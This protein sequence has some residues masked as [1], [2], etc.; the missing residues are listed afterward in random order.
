[1]YDLVLMQVCDAVEDREE[2]A[3]G[4]LKM[5]AVDQGRHFGFDMSNWRPSVPVIRS[6]SL[7]REI[8]S[9]SSSLTVARVA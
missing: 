4:W 2:D 6:L 7:L 5:E 3:D 1:M 9:T 8:D